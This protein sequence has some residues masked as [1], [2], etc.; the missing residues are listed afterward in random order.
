MTLSGRFSDGLVH[1]Y[2][3]SLPLGATAFLI[4]VCSN[5]WRLTIRR[6]DGAIDRRGV[7][8][9]TQDIMARLE[10]EFN[11]P[12]AMPAWPH[13]DRRSALRRA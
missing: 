4:W 2:V 7:F 10:D 1:S 8:A 5:G 11:A 12:S 3:V 6:A 13:A 9:T